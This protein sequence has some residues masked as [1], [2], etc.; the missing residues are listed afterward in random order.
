MRI[1]ALVFALAMLTG[2]DFANTPKVPFHSADITGI[3]GYGDNFRLTDHNG[4]PRSMDDFRGKVVA[5][6]FGYTFCP[7]VCPTTLSDMRQ[8]MK[9]LGDKSDQLQ[10]LFVTV[11][12]KRD[13]KDVLARYVPAFHPAFLGLNGDEAQTQKVTRDFKIVA[14]MVPGQSAD[15]YTYDHTAGMLIFDKQGQLRLM[16]PYGIQAEKLTVDIKRL[17]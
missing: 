7:D 6:F 16:A 10:V 3:K 8:V 15:T 9:S 13:T 17:L 2:C 1:I 4:K 5:I 11:D 12:P 14:C